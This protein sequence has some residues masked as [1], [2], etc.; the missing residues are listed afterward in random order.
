MYVNLPVMIKTWNTFE[1][2]NDAPL[3]HT[4]LYWSSI[5]TACKTH[6]ASACR[7]HLCWS[8]TDALP[9]NNFID[10]VLMYLLE[11]HEVSDIDSLGRNT[12]IDQA[13]QL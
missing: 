9:G 3:R 11:T 12:S 7:E 10:Q 1:N 8:G 6:A 5:D 4:P 13:F 2:N